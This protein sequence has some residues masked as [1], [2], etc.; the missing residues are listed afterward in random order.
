LLRHD[1]R[2]HP[3]H[4]LRAQEGERV[5]FEDLIDAVRERRAILFVG[6]GVSKN[7]GVPTTGELVTEIARQ[8]GEDPA[9]FRTYGDHR[10]LAEYYKLKKGTLGPLR[11]WM[12]VTWHRPD[13]DVRSSQIHRLIVDLDFPIIYTTNY[14]RWLER[15]FD[16][17]GKEYA[18]IVNVGDLLKAREGVTQIVKFHGDFDDDTSIVLTESSFFDRLD[19]ES[20]LDIKLQS[21]ALGRPLLFIG[22][23]LSD[24]NIRYLLYKL[25][26]LWQ[27]SLLRSLRPRSFIFL[28]GSNPVQR[29]LLRSRGIEPIES[30]FENPGEGLTRFLSQIAEG[31]KA[32]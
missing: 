6:A 21:D 18:K 25:D 17:F 26:R 13:V 19:F 4:R 2:F 27:R 7:V 8:L 32:R 12:D 23:S 31:V 10:S 29:R 9:I 24:I 28:S 16:E 30:E 14:D 1:A 22:Y 5:S 11:S 20:A 15:T 3:R